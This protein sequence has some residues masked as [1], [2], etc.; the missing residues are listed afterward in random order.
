MTTANENTQQAA[1]NTNKKKKGNKGGSA[2]GPFSV[3]DSTIGPKKYSQNA[4]W[5][6]DDSRLDPA[7]D[8]TLKPVIDAMQTESE[9]DYWR[10]TRD[11]RDAAASRN[12]LGSGVYSD[13]MGRAREEFNEAQ[14]AT[15]A[16]LYNSA[17]EN[18]LNR[19]LEVTNQINQRDIAEGQNRTAIRTAQI[20]IKPGM[21][22]GQAALEQAKVSRGH[23]GLA[24]DQW[25]FEKPWK[26]IGNLIDVM[27]AS[28]DMSGYY[29][30]PQFVGNAQPYGGMSP[31]AGG[32]M[33]GMGGFLNSYGAIKQG[34]M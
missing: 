3:P 4:E 31:W 2:Y 26:N 10:S 19:R 15:I 11:L 7:N 30:Y 13:R 25:N 28:G 14:Q 21:L 23:L 17:R 8:P 5:F 34:A 12:L 9:E 22:Q 16:N 18:A 1:G 33:G 27:R 32:L 24:R 20:S 6:L 29:E